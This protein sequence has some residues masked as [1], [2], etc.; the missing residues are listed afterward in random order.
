MPIFIL[1]FI[2]PVSPIYC[3]APSLL[4]V[5]ILKPKC[6]LFRDQ[7]LEMKTDTR[8]QIIAML[9]GIPGGLSVDDVSDFCSLAR[10]YIIKTPHTFRKV[11]S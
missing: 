1:P 2:H 4:P 7:V 5:V 8:D 9:C 6:Y 10:Y 11:S 3:F